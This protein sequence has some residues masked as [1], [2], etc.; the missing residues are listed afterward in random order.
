MTTITEP[1]A[2]SPEEEPWLELG[3]PLRRRRT[4]FG[5]ATLLLGLVALLAFGFGSESGLDFTFV[6]SRGSDAVQVPDLTLPARTTA[7]VLTVVILVLGTLQV[8]NVL[9]AGIY[10]VF[11][12]A[13]ALFIV[14]LLVWAARGD[15]IS[16]IGLLDGALRRSIPL[17]FGALAGLLCE[18]SGVINIGI[19]GMLLTGAFTAAITA[20]AADNTWVGLLSG[21]AVGALLGAFLAVM[22]IRYRVDQIIGGTV[23]NFLALGMT[24]YLTARVLVE[25]PNLNEPGSFRAFGIPGL[26]RLPFIGP[27]LFDNTIYVYLL[28]AL[29]FGLWWGLFRTRWGL[30]VRAV[31]EHPRAA[32]TVGINV[33]RTRYRSVILGGAVAGLGGTWFTLD[34]VSSFDEN[35]TAGRG[36]IALAAL[37]FGRWHPVGAFIAALVFGFSEEL[38]QR[39]AVLDTPI[40]SEFLL[41]VPYLV[42]IVVVA[43]LVGRSRP[44]AADGKVYVVE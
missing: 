11:G 31:G 15:D 26:E 28:F 42:T 33:L 25:Y 30:R 1:L 5:I 40:P 44:P 24:S 17:A 13:L 18:R 10:L 35:M 37:I 32:D 23:I 41:M 6:F 9:R 7:I 39:L 16:I 20:S 12:I 21:V 22:S 29:V 14:A 43:G 8:L 27:L 19:E 36:F 38:Q 4:G 3:D 34:A 2:P